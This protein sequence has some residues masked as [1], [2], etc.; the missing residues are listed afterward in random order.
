[1]SLEAPLWNF[2][3]FLGFFLDFLGLGLGSPGWTIGKKWLRDLHPRRVERKE[4]EGLEG[5]T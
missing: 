4:W 3:D 2:L 1:M 5:L